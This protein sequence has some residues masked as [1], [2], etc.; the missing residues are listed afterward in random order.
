MRTL[1]LE[2]ACAALVACGQR[3]SGSTSLATVEDIVIYVVGYHIDGNL[4]RQGV[5]AR[6][7]AILRGLTEAMSGTK[8]VM[9][10]DQMRAIIMAYQTRMRDAGRVKD[11][12]RSNANTAEGEKFL[13][14]NRTKPGV[15]ET[16]SGLQW[17]VIREGKGAHPKLTSVATVHY[18]GSLLS[19][20]AFDSSYGGK[21]VS[22]PLNQVI[23]GWGEG[24][25]LMSP[26]A[27]YLFW[28]PA[29]LAYGAAGSPPA[30]GPDQTLVF[31]VELVSF[32]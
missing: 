11:S 28:L 8:S 7:Q 23:A 32:K 13:A 30:I 26:G 31:E 14:E 29:K 18:R 15:K 2:A 19:G 3:S 12:A 20:V 9:S 27:K 25:Q 6:P 24:V 21:P 4:K 1:A 5:P 22:F 16:A 10:E 17:K